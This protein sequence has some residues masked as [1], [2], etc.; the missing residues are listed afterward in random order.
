MHRVRKFKKDILCSIK[1]N[2]TIRVPASSTILSPG[3]SSYD[4]SGVS[5]KMF[6]LVCLKID[7]HVVY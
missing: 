4:H 1:K 3:V 6:H 2:F 5:I 7:F